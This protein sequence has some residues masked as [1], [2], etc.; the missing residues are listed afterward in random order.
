MKD[1]KPSEGDI[2]CQAPEVIIS[3][4][5]SLDGEVKSSH[6]VASFKPYSLDAD[7]VEP[8]VHEAINENKS[9]DGQ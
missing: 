2:E 5:Q 8:L 3:K 4:T 7:C 9:S 1:L 6:L